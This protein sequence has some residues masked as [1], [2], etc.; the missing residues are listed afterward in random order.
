MIAAEPMTLVPPKTPAE[1]YEQYF[2]PAMFLPWAEILLRHARPRT[3]ERVLDIACGTG[4]VARLAAPLVGAEGEVVALDS[5]PAMLAVG[6]SLATP[7]GAAI[8]WREG[9]AMAL[10]F[11][12]G[13]F[14]LAL[15]QHG[16]PFFPDR[17]VAVREMRRVLSPDGRA[18]AI[19]LDHLDRHPVFQAL[20]T[21][22]AH[23]LSLPLSAVATPFALYDAEALRVLFE[24]A[25]FTQVRIHSEST[26]VRFVDPARFI[27]MAVA[28]SAAAVPAF[29]RMGMPERAAI[30]DSVRAD[31]GALIEQ[32]ADGGFVKFP[33]FAHVAAALA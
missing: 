15:C 24:E 8:H 12:P 10:P 9:N 2:V 22:V 3:G 19:V 4:A 20:M 27:P 33:M 30:L 11:A 31:M 29:A 18:C 32:Y 7:P 23:H 16:L 14:D 25:G 21:S 13:R 5:S 1:N 26:V 17:A 28:S 6:R